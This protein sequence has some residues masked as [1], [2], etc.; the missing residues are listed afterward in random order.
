MY[1]Y[2]CV[3]E[4]WLEVVL[5]RRLMQDDNR[6]LGQ[7]VK[8]TV[9]TFESFKLLIERRLSTASVSFGILCATWD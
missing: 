6:G 9:V 5:D 1:N 3:L 2:V 8:D 4:G 7:G